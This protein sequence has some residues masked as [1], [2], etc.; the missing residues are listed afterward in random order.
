MWWWAALAKVLDELAPDLMVIEHFP[1]GKWVLEPE[2]RFCVERM[3]RQKPHAMCLTSIR[4]SNRPTRSDDR[5]H[6]LLDEM[7]DGVLVHSDPAL[8]QPDEVWPGLRSARQPVHFTG[9][10]AESLGRIS[11][12]R[13]P[14]CVVS[15]GAPDRAEMVDVV[16]AAWEELVN[17][18]IGSRRAVRFPDR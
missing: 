2:V 4:E 15:M 16:H 11:K 5:I 6:E 1:L 10:V 13:L 18:V 7:F 3:R 14:H 8:V 17:P 9:F 12:D